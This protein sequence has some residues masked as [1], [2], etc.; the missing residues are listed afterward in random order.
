MIL[1]I[2]GLSLVLG[3]NLRSS[4]VLMMNVFSPICVRQMRKVI[5]R[6][7]DPPR[8]PLPQYDRHRKES[9]VHSRRNILN[10]TGNSEFCPKHLVWMLSMIP[11][12]TWPIK[13]ISGMSAPD[14]P[15]FQRQLIQT[16]FETSVRRFFLLRRK[17]SPYFFESNSWQS[18]GHGVV[19]QE[20][21]KDFPGMEG[22]KP[23]R[24]V[25]PK[26]PCSRGVLYSFH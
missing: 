16:V 9:S 25:G 7:I 24:Q 18:G 20:M 19:F 22:Y 13:M 1:V 8:L 10:R 5:R 15:S 23:S 6:Q 2:L 4:V 14:P 3:Q 11:S 17:R 26:S 21:R 12:R